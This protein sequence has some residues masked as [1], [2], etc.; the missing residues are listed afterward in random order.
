M[1][2]KQVQIAVVGGGIVG[3]SILNAL[4]R[5]GVSDLILIERTELT[6]G[7]TWHAAGL[8][9]IYTA[10]RAM[11]MI[12]KKTIEIYEE[13]ERREGFS[14]GWHPCGNLRLAS[15][16]DRMEEYIAYLP[17]AESFGIDA[18]LLNKKEVR[19]LWPLLEDP[20]ERVI[21]GLYHAKDGHAAPADCTQALVAEARSVGAAVALRTE[22][23]GFER[24]ADSQWRLKSARGDIVAEK[25]V[26]ATGN[27]A[28]QTGKM[29]GLNIP[30]VPIL[31]Q[32]LVGE[33]MPEIQDR[34]RSG[35]PELPILRDDKFRG[36]FR[37]EGSGLIFGPYETAENVQHFAVDGVPETF[38]AARVMFA[39]CFTL[40]NS[41]AVVE[42]V[43]FP[44]YPPKVSSRSLFQ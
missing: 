32:Y 27:Y 7:S 2:D 36:Y 41:P 22:I 28:R 13:F 42:L 30:A 15:T 16:S 34:K 23:T 4:A 1:S 10:H 33:A 25:V 6:A 5:L 43:S 39:L 18:R 38:G 11:A 31:H 29:F 8:V 44:P 26:V 21:G 20:E 3:A 40:L 37:E 17:I 19:D 9:P 35:M 12:V 14:A 24:T